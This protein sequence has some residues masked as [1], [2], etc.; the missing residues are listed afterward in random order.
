[1]RILCLQLKR[2]GDAILTAPA[3]AAL[4][5]EFPLAHMALVLHGPS[6]QLGPA[7]SVVDEVLVYKPGRPNVKLWGRIVSG[8]WSV[9]YD[10]T[11]TDRSAVM[12]RMS[13]AGRVF[14]YRKFAEKR[15]W[16]VH[17]Y[18]DLSDASVRDLHT[19]D[20][21]LALTGLGMPEDTGFEIPNRKPARLDGLPAGDFIVV[22][23]GSARSEKLW[24]PGRWAEVMAH[25]PMPVVLTGSADPAEQAHLAAILAEIRNPKSEP[26][27]ARQ[28]AAGSPEGRARRPRANPE[29]GGKPASARTRGGDRAGPAGAHR[30]FGGDASGGDGGAAAGGIVR[31]DQSISLAAATRRGAGG[32]GSG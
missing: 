31:A 28:P 17:S 26:S 27:G 25:L 3:L 19:V 8:G 20:F 9:C 7:F 10:F 2:I 23:P 6:G 12:A 15:R 32:A 1:M 16:R 30:G 4:R 24:E 5:E 22:H 21:F 13:R 18:T 14:G 11:G 29:F